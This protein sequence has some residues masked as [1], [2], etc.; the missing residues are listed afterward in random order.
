MRKTKKIEGEDPVGTSNAL[1]EAKKREIAHSQ[2]DRNLSFASKDKDVMDE[3]ML[4]TPL[5]KMDTYSTKFMDVK[6]QLVLA[7]DKIDA[8]EVKAGL[9]PRAADITNYFYEEEEPQA[10]TH[11]VD[12]D[13]EDE[14]D[15][16]ILYDY[17]TV[18]SLN[19]GDYNAFKTLS[20]KITS[21]KRRYYFFDEIEDGMASKQGDFVVAYIRKVGATGIGFFFDLYDGGELSGN[22]LI[23]SVS[24]AI[25]L[26]KNGN[27]KEDVIWEYVITMHS[28]EN[29]K[30]KDAIIKTEYLKMQE[31]MRSIIVTLGILPTNL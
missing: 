27:T 20:A 1:R 23:P 18:L 21:D 19:D 14:E 8:P 9:I 11:T 15:S 16:E 4:A 30:P 10:P 17:A 2:I 25:T 29:K 12:A 5:A 26:M 6:D 28:N 13:A 24:A 22:D 7:V 3:T 31:F